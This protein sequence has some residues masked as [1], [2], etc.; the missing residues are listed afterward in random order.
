MASLTKVQLIGR[1][2]RDPETRYTP[3]G[4]AVTSFS[5]ATDDYYMKKDGSKEKTT[6]WHLI[7]TF[8][9]IAENCGKYL[10]KGSMVYIEGKLSTDSWEDKK[11]EGKMNKYVEEFLKLKSSGDI[12]NV[13]NP[14]TKAEKEIT[15]SMAVIKELR[16]I[17]LSAP[18]DYDLY[19]LCA[20]NA[21]TSVIASFLLPFH[22]V[23]A[24]DKHKRKRKWE[25]VQRFRYLEQDITKSDFWKAPNSIFIGVHTCGNLAKT[26]INRYNDS[27]AKYLILMPCCVG[28]IE[29]GLPDFFREKL[30][31][32]NIWTWEL[33][34]L[35]KGKVR[36]KHDT[37]I[38]SPCN[39]LIIATK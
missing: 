35:V 22:T 16:S 10:E 3:S 6:E 26:I 15:E 18:M 19:D 25:A 8:G 1:L 32:Y 17:A 39:N 36:I 9:R 38:I 30:G 21:L 23:T 31:K 28:Q 29:T 27:D 11:G 4:T 20:G 33:S 34:R 2:G 7:T 13:C 5:I 24:I 37:N 12:L 14:I